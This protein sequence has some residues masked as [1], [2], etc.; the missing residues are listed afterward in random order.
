M[1]K[2]KNKKSWREKLTEEHPSH[3]KIIKILIPKPLDVDAII[4]T[5][6][7]GKLVTDKQI[8]EKL[9]EDYQADSTCSKVTGI[10]LRIAAE[11]AEED[12]QDGIADITPY[13]RVVNKEGCLKPKFPG[14]PQAQAARLEKEGHTIT[15]EEGKKPP[16]VEDFGKYLVNL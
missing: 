9:A 5:V 12:A 16:K 10:F 14:G 4:R 11:A 13:W 8:R 7:E 1:S 2:K 15:P 6:P 3:G